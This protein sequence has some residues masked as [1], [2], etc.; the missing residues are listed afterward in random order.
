MSRRNLPFAA[1]AAMAMLAASCAQPP[2]PDTS[3]CE[4]LFRD[5]DLAFRSNSSFYQ[6]G[7][8]DLI[9][10]PVFSRLSSQLMSNG[11]ITKSNDLANLDELRQEIL[12]NRR[13]VGG[14]A[15]PPTTI[16]V[17]AVTSLTDEILVLSFFRALGYPAR[18]I[19]A[20]EIGKRIFVGGLVTEGTVNEVLDISRRAGFVAPYVADLVRF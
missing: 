15:V 14:A 6:R 1:I 3:R 9:V 13:S 18:S 8:D 16:S 7:G 19:G 10:R 2:V 20:E 12:S 11:C 4:G 17:G 5:Y